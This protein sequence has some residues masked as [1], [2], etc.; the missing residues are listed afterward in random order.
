LRANYR[1]YSSAWAGHAHQLGHHAVGIAFLHD[2][3][4]QRDID[5]AI[6]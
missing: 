1:A 5:A 3:Q 4:R 2:G 6:G